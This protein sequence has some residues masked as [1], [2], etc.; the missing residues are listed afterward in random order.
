MSKDDSITLSRDFS[1]AIDPCL[2]AK[3]CGIDPDPVQAKLL[4]STSRKVLVNACRQFGKSSVTGLVA[5]HEALYHAPAMIIL[6]SPSQQQSQ[7]IYR[8]VHGYWERLPGAPAAD[9][10]LLT[11]MQ[12]SNGS[13]IISLPGSERTV[14]GYSAATLIVIDEASRVPDDLVAA[15]RPMLATTNG[16]LA[17]L[18][19]PSGK[20]GFFHETWT[21]G[22]GWERFRVTGEECPRISKEFLEEQ[23]QELGPLKYAQE[24][25]CEFVD[26]E[27]SVFNSDLIQ[28]AL[29]NDFKPFFS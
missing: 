16:R 26:A 21:Q 5:L 28:K 24:F 22:E 1:R 7:E 10:E 11:R 4:T 14:R 12:L 18:S 13:R 9:Q 8:K 20:R 23:R 29:T 2:L 3:D 25:G 19:T 17:V 15:V 6:I 27:T